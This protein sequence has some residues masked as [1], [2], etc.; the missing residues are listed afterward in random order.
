MAGK[1]SPQYVINSYQRKSRLGTYL[2]WGI[3]GI[4]FGAGILLLVLWFTGGGGS[5]N[6]GSLFA[7]ATPT[8]TETFTPTPTVPTNTPTMTP[9]ETETPTPTLT[10][11]PEGP[12]MYTV[13]EGDTCWNIAVDFGVNFELFMTINNFSLNECPIGPGDQVVIPGA[14][15]E[16]PTATP[17]PLEQY[18]TGQ[19][20]EYIVEMNDSY[21][22]IASKFNTTLDSL[23]KLN[24]I[25]DVTDFPQIGQVLQIAVNLVTPTPTPVPTYTEVPAEG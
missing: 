15:T 25:E 2:L 6:I 13:Q 23:S 11:T 10:P 24:D 18:T 16:M 9:T 21:Q 19:R 8:P 12:Q 4:I 7:S 3:A 20:I 22:G 14:D 1:N 5:F 17:I